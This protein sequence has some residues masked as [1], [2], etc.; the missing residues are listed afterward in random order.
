[1]GGM[2][3][4]H[5]PRCKAPVTEIPDEVLDLGIVDTYCESCKLHA[6]ITRRKKGR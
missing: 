3:I 4:L 5:C 6:D 2:V 1:M